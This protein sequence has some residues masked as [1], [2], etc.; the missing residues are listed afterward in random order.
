VS[1]SAA[2]P[3]PRA[4]NRSIPRLISQSIAE[5]NG[6]CFAQLLADEM[7][8]RGYKKCTYVGYAG[9]IDSNPKDGSSGKHKYVRATV[10]V[11]NSMKQ[12]EQGRVS[13]ARTQFTPNVILKKKSFLAKLFS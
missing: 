12:V 11:R 3:R 7:Y 8:A 1:T 10:K 6:A 13:E 4:R 9:S 5:T 2:L